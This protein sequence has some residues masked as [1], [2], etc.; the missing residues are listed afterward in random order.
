[1]SDE[2][3]TVGIDQFVV[4]Q[5]HGF[6]RAGL[7][8][9]RR[10][11][12]I[13]MR[14]IDLQDHVGDLN[15][16]VEDD[17]FRGRV[18]SGIYWPTGNPLF[19][20]TGEFRW[21][22]WPAITSRASRSRAS[23]AR[24][25]P[26]PG[27]YFG[28]RTTITGASASAF[29]VF[30]ASWA[31][32]IRFAELPISIWP[33]G[34]DKLAAGIPLIVLDAQREDQQIPLG[35][36]AYDPLV[37]HW[38]N[39]DASDCSTYVFDIDKKGALDRII[40][41]H[42]DTAWRVTGDLDPA[43]APKPVSKGKPGRKL[44][45]TPIAPFGIN[46]RVGR[47]GF[48]RSGSVDPLPGRY[49]LG[50]NLT[51]SPGGPGGWGTCVGR[52]ISGERIKDITQ[53]AQKI[54][55]ATGRQGAIGPLEA[56]IAEV[57]KGG[58][59]A[60]ELIALWSSTERGGPFTA[61]Q[62]AKDPHRIGTTIDGLPLLP[63]HF[64]TIALFHQPGSTND[65]PL[66]FEGA[67]TNTG[68][69]F[70]TLVN[71]HLL[72][73]NGIWGWVTST[74]WKNPIPPI[75]PITPPVPPV[76]PI[77][78]PPRQPP[79]P[80]PPRKPLKQGQI[81]HVGLR[82]SRTRHIGLQPDTGK[83][84]KPPRDE[85]TGPPGRQGSTVPFGSEELGVPGEVAPSPEAQPREIIPKS[86]GDTPADRNPMHPGARAGLATHL[87]MC[88][89]SM[90]GKPQVR[91]VRDL[92]YQA[93]TNGEAD[94]EALSMPTTWRKL[95]FGAMEPSLSRYFRTT[96][97]PSGRYIGGAGDGGEVFCPPQLDIE[98][99]FDD[100]QVPDKLFTELTKTTFQLAFSQ[101]AIARKIQRLTGCPLD[102]WVLVQD[103]VTGNVVLQSVDLAGV[104]PSADIE[105]SVFGQQP[106]LRGGINAIVA[107][108]DTET[109]EAGKSGEASFVRDNLNNFTMRWDGALT[110]DITVT[111]PGGLQ[112]GETEAADEWLEVH[113]ID[114]T[115]GVNATALLLIPEGVAFS[116]TGYDV[117]QRIHSVRNDGSSNLL[118]FGVTGKGRYRTVMYRIAT[119]NRVVLS[120]GNAT[121]PT[122]IDL[123]PF[124]PPTSTFAHAGVEQAG[125]PSVSFRLSAGGVPITTL[126]KQQVIAGMIECNE[127]QQIFYDNSTPAGSVDFV[128]RGY[129]EELC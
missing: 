70:D 111:G 5:D 89:N 85:A 75:P 113:V 63:L 11:V 8:T 65:G 60:G 117:N 81:R 7:D 126:N 80:P 58:L 103:P 59:G 18:T 121:V 67:G 112:T 90:Y 83:P 33:N 41:A 27:T 22:A 128:V 43:L 49:M 91:T 127:S 40:K 51:E 44:P 35:F 72:F 71:V 94:Q 76:P 34:P 20:P 1:M 50:W 48:G 79:V 2:A 100:A 120:G 124:V 98:L 62:G 82:P 38:R 64:A 14:F 97:G 12:P 105:F 73:E 88:V 23:N 96:K 78:G 77:Q 10:L 66:R 37:A 39:E 30:D 46:T 125:S 17:R 104:I 42:L 3:G 61:G 19:R 9:M 74:P 101:L 68:T 92:R 84:T 86:I 109:V 6:V 16:H 24:K 26:S 110:A 122:A 118:D 95:T 13:G 93:Q 114:D 36:T 29:P 31:A 119:V 47:F 56:V 115:S 102:G 54:A 45:G 106:D 107:F 25:N 87:D 4:L 99:L 28:T 108:V 53:T 52:V 57:R 55:K 123:S 15:E 69:D 116:E 129:V 32:D 21:G